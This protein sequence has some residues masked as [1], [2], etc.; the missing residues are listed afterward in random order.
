MGWYST[1]RLCH[2]DHAFDFVSKPSNVLTLTLHT[3]AD[4]KT[5]KGFR[6]EYMATGIY[7]CAFYIIQFVLNTH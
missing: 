3:V 6:L 1:L 4:Q 5:P 7:I 2:E